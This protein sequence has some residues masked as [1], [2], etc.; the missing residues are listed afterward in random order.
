MNKKKWFLASAFAIVCALSLSLGIVCFL[1]LSGVVVATAA[2]GDP[3][4]EQ[5]PR[6][7]PFCL[8]VGLLAII[9]LVA[10]FI[11]YLKASKK[12]AFTQ[13]MCW[14]PVIISVVISAPMLLLWGMLFDY[15]QQ[16][17]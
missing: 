13:T 9:A 11:T 16:V 10:T 2:F 1:H 3:I 15:L 8:F 4:S 6:F 12:L 17:F 14:I 5:Y 7:I